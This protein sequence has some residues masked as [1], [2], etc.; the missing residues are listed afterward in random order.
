MFKII[1]S[2]N[3]SLIDDDI[4]I[5]NIIVELSN[6]ITVKIINMIYTR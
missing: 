3:Y 2:S 1:I 4:D 6:E 5:G